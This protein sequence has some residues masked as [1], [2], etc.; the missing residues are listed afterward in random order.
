MQFGYNK[1][2]SGRVVPESKIVGLQSECLNAGMLCLLYGFYTSAA[3][4]YYDQ[5]I[6]I[7]YYNAHYYYYTETPKAFLKYVDI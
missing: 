7:Y 2:K 5:A 3:M 6:V 4:H 1:M